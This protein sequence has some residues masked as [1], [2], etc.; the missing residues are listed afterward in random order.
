MNL[1][2][3]DTFDL[4]LKKKNKIERD[5]KLKYEEGKQENEIYYHFSSSFV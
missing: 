1:K 4:N 2:E 5:K 3:N